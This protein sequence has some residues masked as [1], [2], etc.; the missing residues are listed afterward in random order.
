MVER[1]GGGEY[2]SKRLDNRKKPNVERI[3]EAYWF[4]GHELHDV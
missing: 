3:K 4:A 2:Y 1:R